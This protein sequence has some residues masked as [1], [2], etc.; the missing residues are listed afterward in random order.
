MSARDLTAR[1]LIGI[2]LGD[3]AG[4]ATEIVVKSLA[5][6]DVSDACD[7]IV[8]GDAR[9]VEEALRFAPSPMKVHAVD[10]VDDAR[11]SPGTIN[12]L[13]ARNLAPGDF[14]VGKVD[15]RCG[16]AF[17]EYIR[18]AGRLALDGTIDAIASAPTNKESM[19]AAGYR[20]PGQT[21]IFAELCGTERF[22][23]VLTGG[24]L[25]VFLIS[26]HVSLLRAIQLVDRQRVESVIRIANEALRD[27][28]RIPMPRIAVAG[29]NPHAGDGG[30]FGNEEIEH[31]IPV[32]TRLAADGIDVTGPF[33]ADSL[34]HAAEAGKYDGIVGMYHDQGVI[35]LKKYG[36]V[37]VIAGTPI[38]RTT[39]G[40]GTAYDI[41]GKGVADESVMAR[42]ITTA[43]ELAR[44]RTAV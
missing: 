24:R 5:R 39:A 8:I 9:V 31:V 16:A 32:I 30:L 6:Q 35:P 22:F 18:T 34:Y 7:S 33:P 41:A 19:N 29:L 4:I 21:E 28:W 11:F 15:A 2:T 13:D 42:A 27:L 12:V 23:T 40:H 20:Y 36:Y 44:L 37:T 1:P 43:A 26:S 17:V 38:L 10:R 25:R 3:A 14:H